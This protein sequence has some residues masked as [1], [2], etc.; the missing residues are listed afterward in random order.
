M[1]DAQIVAQVITE[2]AERHQIKAKAILGYRR[3]ADVCAARQELMWRLFTESGYSLSSIARLLDR[4]HTTIRSGI[5]KVRKTIDE[6]AAWPVR[7]IH[8]NPSRNFEA[9]SFELRSMATALK[10]RDILINGRTAVVV[11][12]KS[13]KDKP[14]K[15]VLRPKPPKPVVILPCTATR[16][17]DRINRY[18]ARHGVSANARA[19]REGQRIVVRSDVELVKA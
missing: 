8:F 17:A 18:W 7:N 15:K 9:G 5:A 6:G 13:Q 3:N 10:A 14:R 2:V 1:S 12:R 4:D 19:E 11:P 16:Q